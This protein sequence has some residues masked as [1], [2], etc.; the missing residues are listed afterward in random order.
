MANPT[1]VR[2]DLE[3]VAGE[4]D[5]ILTEIYGEYVAKGCPTKLGGLR[6]LDVE[7]SK[8]FA[9]ERTGTTEDGAGNLLILSA[10]FL[11][12]EQEVWDALREGPGG[13]RLVPPLKVR[14]SAD[15]GKADKR[16]VEITYSLPT[17]ELLTD[18]R[19]L[20]H[21]SRHRLPN[22]R[23]ALAGILKEEI[24][25]FAGAVMEHLIHLIRRQG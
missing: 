21:A 16:F 6:F 18:E 12:E 5:V 1:T 3:R 24:L 9:F 10:P 23:E 11:G 13:E 17:S 19:I 25:P 8:T 2:L 4:I 20:E 14:G 7:S 22:A 15:A